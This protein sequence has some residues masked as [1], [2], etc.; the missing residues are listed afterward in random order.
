[1]FLKSLK[2]ESEEQVIREINFHKGLN[3]IVD[4][5]PTSSK[6]TGN[7]IGKTTVL[8]LIDYCLGA[9][10]KIIYCDTETKKEEY[11]YVKEFLKDEKVLI[12]LILSEELDNNSK[13]II[14][15][16]NFLRG[17][18]NIRKIN[19]TQIPEKEYDTILSQLMFKNLT[20][21]KPTFRQIIS[22][23]IR[24][25]D[26]SINNTLRTLN[27]Y[28]SDAEYETLYLFLLDCKFEEGARKQELLSKIQ[29]EINYKERLEKKETKNAFE[30]SLAMVESEIEDLTKKKNNLN[31]NPNFETDLNELNNVKYNINK[32]SSKLTNLQ[33]RK[34]LI[35]D[36]EKEIVSNKSN[37]DLKQLEIVYKQ[38]TDKVSDLQKTFEDLVNFHNNML[39]E[40]VKFITKELPQI[41]D[42]IK[43]I[44]DKIKELLEKEKILTEKISKSDSFSQLE[45]LV[46]LIN[47]QYRKKGEYESILSQIEE[48]ENNLNE[49]T[50]DLDEID[51]KLFSEQF[52]DTLRQKVKIFNKYFSAVSNELYGE[53]YALK[54]D[55][56]INKKG[57][58]LFKFNAFNTNL[59][60][61]KKQG[62]I[63][64]FDLAY[65]IF[66]EEQNIP[67]IKFLL[68][69][70]KELMHDN[71]LEQ[72]AEFLKEKDIQ[73][74]VSILK[75]KLPDELNNEDYFIVKLS[76]NSK[77]FR[78]EEIYQ[79]RKELNRKIIYK[80][81]TCF[82]LQVLFLCYFIYSSPS[83][84]I[85]VT[86]SFLYVT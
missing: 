28:T 11:T 85:D 81:R 46:S 75:D 39:V 36:T 86:V 55:K 84:I 65:I 61:G 21:D 20:S 35:Q 82:V 56:I 73:L 54:Y 27:S 2:I 59:S 58:Q 74:I 14:I 41:E 4:E 47:E 30:I 71:Q 60:S 15:Q 26:E 53:K 1:M 34:E 70:K 24:Y 72:V 12:T 63:L 3:L 51:K 17:K 76:P 37:I 33:I 48:I 77:L 10:E 69:D 40:K 7:N 25:K 45:E 49:Y 64:C 8:K 38:A 29:Q 19:G 31:I 9:N 42:E 67:C 22:H 5:T 79:K 18:N 13:E 80:N 50:Q 32:I 62:E 6:E 44:E 83:K 66:A 43:I 57:Q 52:E 23:N 68:N 78:I 16:R